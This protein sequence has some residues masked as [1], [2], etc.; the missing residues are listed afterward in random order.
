MKSWSLSRRDFLAG[1][2]AGGVGLAAAD[3]TRAES[4]SS[5]RPRVAALFTELRLRSHA[6]NILENFF[7]PYLFNGELVDPGVD[8]ASFYADQFPDSD[9]AR[10][11][12]QR[13]KA[14]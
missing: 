9:L 10:E 14:P 12:S 5:P 8:M 1:S 11:V 4:D 7:A 2:L 13:F 6:Y 3:A